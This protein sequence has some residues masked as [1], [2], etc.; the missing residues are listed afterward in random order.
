M[1]RMTMKADV[2]V[3][4]AGSGGLSVAS[5]AAQLG[6]KVALFERAEMGGDCLNY[7]CVPSKAL[8]AAAK[9]AHAM[10]GSG[11]LGVSAGE[12]RVDFAAVMAHVHGAIAAIA[13]HDS[14]ERFENFG[15]R[16]IREHARF[17]D[18]RTVASGSVAVEA[19]RIVIA[20]GSRAKIPP[21]P[22]LAELPYLTN[23]TIFGLAE[24]PR[25]LVVIGGG[26]IGVEL[27]QAFRRLGA[28]V[29]LISRGDILSRE[30]PDAAAVVAEQ[31]R[32][33]GIELL[34]HHKLL[35]AAAGPMLTVEGK[36]GR[37]HI[38]GSHLLVAAGREASLDR[39]DLEKAGVRY[40]ANGVCTDRRLRSSNPRVYAVGDAAGR[41]Q[42]THL[43]G[44]HAGLFIRNALFR[45]PVDAD[46]LVVPRVVYSDPELAAVGLGEAEARE[47]FGDKVRIERFDFAGNDRAT[48][49][50][51]RRGFGKLIARSD[52]RILGAV[53]VG[54]GAGDIIHQWVLAMSAGLKLSKLTGM[55]AP[56]PT[57]GELP[58]RLAGQYYTPALFSPRTRRLVSLL[59][60]LP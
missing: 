34:P 60:R 7:G 28:E 26:P 55:I 12:V 23:E 18:R 38:E 49:E 47:R 54:A 48:A 16:V 11:K 15:V 43:A 59:N 22:G 33:D 52:G 45:L 46:A 17:V 44:A 24:L 36:N 31:L 58:K 37:R 25:R 20:T 29:A 21:V 56:Y 8:L 4:G 1:S 35:E 10:R 57:R 2:A 40:D 27:G 39:L 53:I 51:D 13:P 3:I 42:Y 32:A 6:L 19:K 9:A 50:G 5:G 30:D 14:Q 41:G